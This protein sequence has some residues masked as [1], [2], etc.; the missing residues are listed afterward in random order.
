M[1]NR[2]SLITWS[3]NASP[4]RWHS[5]WEQEDQKELSVGDLGSVPGRGNSKRKGSKTV[6]R[7][8]VWRAGRQPVWPGGEVRR[9]QQDHILWALQA[10][11]KQRR[12]WPGFLYIRSLWLLG[13]RGRGKTGRQPGRPSHAYRQ[14]VLGTWT[15]WAVTEVMERRIWVW[16]L[17]HR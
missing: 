8:C 2:D 17:F 5:S 13:V 3:R 1:E 6:V 9:G 11:V 14:E 4:R 12:R 15:R 16:E 10:S 7:G